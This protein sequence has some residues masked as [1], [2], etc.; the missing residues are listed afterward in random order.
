MCASL[1]LEDEYHFIFHCSLYINIRHPFLHHV[2]NTVLNINEM[3]VVDKIQ[4]FM[5]KVY[6]SCIAK[7]IS[8]MIED[9]DDK[10]LKLNSF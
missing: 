2:G 5:S 6:V 1:V 8:K 4:M 7:I 10:L 9:R 3:N